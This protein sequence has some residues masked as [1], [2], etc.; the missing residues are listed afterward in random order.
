DVRAFIE[1][2]AP[3][4]GAPDKYFCIVFTNFN[5]HYS[6]DDLAKRARWIYLFSEWTERAP[7]EENTY[8]GL[9]Q[10]FD[11]SSKRPEGSY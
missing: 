3:S 4:E 7:R 11:F 10:A 8:V 6:G 1:S 2:G 5:W 9:M